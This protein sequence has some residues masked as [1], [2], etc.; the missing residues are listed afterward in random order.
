[1]EIFLSLHEIVPVYIN[2]ITLIYAVKTGKIL[3]YRKESLSP[4]NIK[5]VLKLF[6]ES[7][8]YINIQRK[9][10][11]WAL[12]KC[13]D[14]PDDEYLSP[15]GEYL[16]PYFK[17]ENGCEYAR[18]SWLDI[19]DRICFAKKSF[20][21]DQF[22]TC[23]IPSNQFFELWD[24]IGSPQI[25]EIIKES[26]FKKSDLIKLIST[27]ENREVTIS[28]E[29][30]AKILDTAK[31]TVK[32]WTKKGLL[33]DKQVGDNKKILL[34]PESILKWMQQQAHKAEKN[35]ENAALH[36]WNNRIEKF[37]KWLETN[38]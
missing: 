22:E 18:I 21:R 19:Y 2:E 38:K 14:I 24:G 5:D 20:E 32:S 28:I 12:D 16:F 6:E 37:K 17:Y 35:N 25:L 31:N 1:M 8:R 15:D 30:L 34:L 36:K 10:P 27:N 29:Q 26:V 23:N 11:E 9:T 33:P 13:K 3:P 7:R 4:I